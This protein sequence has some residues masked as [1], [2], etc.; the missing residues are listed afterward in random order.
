MSG[1]DVLNGVRDWHIECGDAL[2]VLRAL[3]DECV[4]TCITSPPYFGL[5]DFGMDGQIGLET[6]PDEYTD[7]L[8]SVLQEVRRVL[9]N[10]GTLWLNLGDSYANPSQAGRGNPTIG[11]RNL[12]GTRQP[13]IPV[14]DGMKPKDLLTLDKRG[15]EENGEIQV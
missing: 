4:Q 14:P 8:V 10:D 7:K 12:G 2:E 6:T 9:R 5:R 11:D 13:R 15:A 1:A 3:P